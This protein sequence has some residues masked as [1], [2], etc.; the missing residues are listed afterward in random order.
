MRG[1]VGRA[2]IG[3]VAVLALSGCWGVKGGPDNAHYYITVTK[4]KSAETVLYCYG[5]YPGP[6]KH[7]ERAHCA[8]DVIR[9]A[10]AQ[11]N[12]GWGQDCTTFTDHTPDSTYCR[13][14][15]ATPERCQDTMVFA[16]ASVLQNDNDCLVFEHSPGDF[17]MSWRWMA[18][19]AG[20]SS[21]FQ[22][23]P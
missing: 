2:V 1:R 23:Y 4:Q 6:D 19:R 21:G 11:H 5:K 17:G 10:C 13:D 15:V 18:T 22:C 9:V 3:A 7:F 16:V 20:P 8:M 14:E 12:I